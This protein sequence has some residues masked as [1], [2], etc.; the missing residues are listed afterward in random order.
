MK[1]KLLYIDDETDSLSLMAEIAKQ[2]NFQCDFA[3]TAAGCLELLEKNHDAYGLILLDL[4]LG[5]SM[6]GSVLKEQISEKYP[7]L[8][9]IIYTGYSQEIV[10]PAMEYWSKND[11]IMKIGAR[12]KTILDGHTPHIDEVN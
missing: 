12:I 9:V 6:A 10:P 2:E 11:D 1:N 3:T 8:R 5:I 4:N 7:D